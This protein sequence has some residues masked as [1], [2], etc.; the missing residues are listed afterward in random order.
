MANS[1]ER[2]EDLEAGLEMVQDES[3]RMNEGTTDKFRNMRIP[4][5]G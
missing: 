5:T 2:L 4:S 3:Q 1:N